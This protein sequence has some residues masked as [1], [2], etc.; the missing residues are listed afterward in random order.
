MN[1]AF[2]HHLDANCLAIAISDNY[3]EII[4]G[5]MPLGKRP[6]HPEHKDDRPGITP[7]IRI[8]IKKV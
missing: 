8:S 6:Q 5:Y 3:G 1:I 7:C 2:P 4:D